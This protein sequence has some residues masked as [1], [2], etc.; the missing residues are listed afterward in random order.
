[1][2]HSHFN[3]LPE[4]LKH[5]VLEHPH[6]PA[7]WDLRRPPLTFEE[8]QRH[9]AELRHQARN[10]GLNAGK[11]VAILL[12]QPSDMA[13]WIA[14]LSAGLT[15]IPLPDAMSSVQIKQVFQVAEPD[16]LIHDHPRTALIEQAAGELSIPVLHLEH[17]HGQQWRY[18]LKGA[19][20]RPPSAVWPAPTP[21]DFALILMTS[22]STQSPKLVP[23]THQAICTTIKASAEMLA[24]KPNCNYLN[25][26]P[27]NHVHGLV[28]GVFL[29][30]SAG[31]CSVSPGNFDGRMFFDWLAASRPD[32][33]ST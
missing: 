4:L 1:M 23:V 12:K 26:M 11:T 30:W 32:W 20:N 21:S 14:A 10:A 5:Q 18:H 28:S 33:F 3:T 7:L 16:A 27:L 29:P 2:G 22:G 17:C 8:M 25:V 24:L 15:C 6:S 19:T 31:Q 13:L 9:I